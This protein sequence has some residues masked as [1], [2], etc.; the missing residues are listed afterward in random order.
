MNF[1][2]TV[3]SFKV[4]NEDPVPKKNDFHQFKV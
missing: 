4:I 3:V 2:I 1:K